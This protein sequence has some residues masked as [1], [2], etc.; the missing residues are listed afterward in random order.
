M[1]SDRE[2]GGGGGRGLGLSA[3]HLMLDRVEW[4]GE[5]WLSLWAL[6]PSDPAMCV[7]VSPEVVGRGPDRRQ[8]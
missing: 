8:G 7:G 4:G 2:W 5:V 3:E 1:V 6:L